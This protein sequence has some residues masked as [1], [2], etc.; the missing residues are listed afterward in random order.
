MPITELHPLLD[1]N[2][3]SFYLRPDLKSPQGRWRLD[4]WSPEPDGRWALAVNCAVEFQTGVGRTTPALIGG[5]GQWSYCN[6]AYFSSFLP[7]AP[8][9]TRM[10]PDE[11]R[12]PNLVTADRHST[13]LVRFSTQE[14]A[15]TRCAY[16]NTILF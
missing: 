4:I 15:D 1:R 16:H 6:M 8:F 9:C 10:M 12:R 14:L 11:P 3:T 5:S 7:V 2:G 13:S